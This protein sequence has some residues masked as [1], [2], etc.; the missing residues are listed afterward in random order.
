MKPIARRPRRF[1]RRA[2][3]LVAASLLTASAHA[4]TTFSQRGKACPVGFGCIYDTYIG[5]WD[6]RS[7]SQGIDIP[8]GDSSWYQLP[9]ELPNNT[10]QVRNR[11]ATT[12]RSVVIRNREGRCLALRYD[13]RTWVGVGG[14]FSAHSMKATTVSRAS[15]STANVS[16]CT[17][18]RWL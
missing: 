9:Y 15:G 17:S 12:R 13:D 2:V 16:G 7:F 14:V 4:E 5:S 8:A 11:N 18:T 3:V 1:R 6:P 10:N